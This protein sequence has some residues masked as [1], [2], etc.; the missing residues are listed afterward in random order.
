M[1][2]SKKFITTSAVIL[3][4]ATPV[5][6]AVS[7]LNTVF[8]ESVPVVNGNKDNSTKSLLDANASEKDLTIKQIDEF[9]DKLNEGLKSENKALLSETTQLIRDYFEDNKMIMNDKLRYSLD[10]IDRDGN[11]LGYGDV[12]IGQLNALKT[13]ILK[14]DKSDIAK[15]R[16]R[17]VN[18]NGDFI[19]DQTYD[20]QVD[21][22]FSIP[23]LKGY[24]TLSASLAED[25]SVVTV[26]VAKGL[27][28]KGSGTLTVVYR[29]DKVK[30][31][32][33]KPVENKVDNKITENK[34]NK[35]AENKVDNKITENKSNKPVENKVDN[36]TTENK[37][38]KIAENKSN[39]IA[40]DKVDNKAT[41]NKSNK[42]DE[43]KADN[44]TTDNKS[45]K[46]AE[47]K[48]DN[49]TTDDKSD[50]PVENKVDDKTTENK[51]DDTYGKT[52]VD[53]VIT[54][55]KFDKLNDTEVRF[56][57]MIDKTKLSEN[58][59]LDGDYANVIITGSNGE[60]LGTLSVR[61]DYKF[62]GILKSQPKDG[63]NLIIKYGGKNYELT[64]GLDKSNSDQSQSNTSNGNS[65]NSDSKT[66][67][68]RDAKA[69][70]LPSTGQQNVV[71]V[72]VAGVIMV[73]LG[74][75]ALFMK[76]RHK[77]TEE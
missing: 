29:E 66:K 67:E 65:Q 12:A 31:E 16:V 75:T 45:D 58:Q 64:Y 23:K 48:V 55:M 32:L 19:S 22:M 42:T 52:T 9:I 51:S 21:D 41:D 46:P 2:K 44:K 13:R 54:Q 4:M 7:N 1:S 15:L 25:K 63:E 77:K 70:L 74:L 26:D 59:K 57:G 60:E 39:K 76:F 6:G 49:K 73:G 18:T 35:T 43:N 50:K 30:A 17:A 24:D 36:K 68:K 33:N 37:S 28:V 34:S 3:S 5:V 27:K 61:D 14:S 69:G 20:V 38:N 53:G 71:G 10:D 47:N 62:D 8:A 11:L 56:S 40:E 72:V